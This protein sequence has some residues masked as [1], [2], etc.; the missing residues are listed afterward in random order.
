M[1]PEV[2]IRVVE[3]FRNTQTPEQF[4]SGL[5]PREL[6]LLKLLT[7]GHQKKTADRGTG[8]QHSHGEFSLAIDL[9]E[10]ARAFA[11]GGGCPR[12]PRRVVPLTFSK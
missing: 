8:N 5:S 11:L 12:A 4:S 10:A 3:L 6:Q 2:A 9:R 7:E 1:S